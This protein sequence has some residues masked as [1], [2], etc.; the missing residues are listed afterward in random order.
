MLRISFSSRKFNQVKED[1]HTRYFT[2]I[3]ENSNMAKEILN[4]WA[5]KYSRMKHFEDCIIWQ[6][7]DYFLKNS[8]K[9][10]NT[11]KGTYCHHWS[12]ETKANLKSPLIARYNDVSLNL[13]FEILFTNFDFIKYSLYICMVKLQSTWSSQ[14]I[15]S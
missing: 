9:G 15:K 13:S 8:L 4:F 7:K 2:S 5:L 6:K 1:A 3:L 14:M 11:V 10:T 12:R